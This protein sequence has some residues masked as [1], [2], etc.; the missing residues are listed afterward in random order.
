MKEIQDRIYKE[1]PMPQGTEIEFGGLRQKFLP[2]DK[3]GLP[4]RVSRLGNRSIV[5]FGTAVRL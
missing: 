4:L 1:V 5:Y 3:G 2:W